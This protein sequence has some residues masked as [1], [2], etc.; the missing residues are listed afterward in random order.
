MINFKIKSNPLYSIGPLKR[1]Q[2]ALASNWH[3][4]MKLWHYDLKHFS[5][6]RICAYGTSAATPMIMISNHI[7]SKKAF[8]QDSITRSS[9]KLD[10]LT[11]L[12]RAFQQLVNYFKSQTSVPCYLF[13]LLLISKSLSKNLLPKDPLRNGERLFFTH[14]S[15][16][17]W[18]QRNPP[19]VKH[20]ELLG[21][22]ELF[23]ITTTYC[24]R[25]RVK[26]SSK[27]VPYWARTELLM[28]AQFLNT[29]FGGKKK[30]HKPD[31]AH[32]CFNC[33]WLTWIAFHL[34]NVESREFLCLLYDH[35]LLSIDKQ[36]K[37]NPIKI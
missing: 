12:D 33:A 15:L 7:I 21:E 16:L 35:P 25:Y 6:K 32:C 31:C 36:N 23:V 28:I 13:F 30:S 11:C 20:N 9:F 24:W 14:I 37:T 2:S 22:L 4:T 3:H 18:A 17:T 5:L 29:A 1:W 19:F 27:E 10:N 8:M 34:C 26:G